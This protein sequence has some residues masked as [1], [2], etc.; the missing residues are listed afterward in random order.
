MKTEQRLS[1]RIVIRILL[2]D[3]FYFSYLKIIFPE[4]E[5]AMAMLLRWNRLR[6]TADQFGRLVT[7]HHF[8]WT[9]WLISVF[10]NLYLYLCICVCVKGQIQ[11]T[12]LVITHHFLWTGWATV[13]ICHLVFVF[14]S[15]D[16]WKICTK[17]VLTP[18]FTT[19]SP[20]TSPCSP[21]I[22]PPAS[23]ISQIGNKVGKKNKAK[24]SSSKTNTE[25]DFQ[26]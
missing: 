15:M 3:W 19:S 18:C 11:K 1:I 26:L 16:K 17:E 8:L 21:P 22:S 12:Q 13:Y 23:R 25:R 9:G 10:V 14:V 5:K 2:S 6:K 7:T 20:E 24:I 4:R